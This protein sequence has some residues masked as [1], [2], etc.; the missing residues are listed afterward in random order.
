MSLIGPILRNI[1]N[2]MNAMHT[3]LRKETLASR[4][5]SLYKHNGI[6]IKREAISTMNCLLAKGEVLSMPVRRTMTLVTVSPTTMLYDTIA[7]KSINFLH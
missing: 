3:R 5:T 6:V 4:A 2:K 7:E 1:E